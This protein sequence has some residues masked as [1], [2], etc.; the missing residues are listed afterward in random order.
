MFLSWRTGRFLLW[1]KCLCGE[2][3]NRRH[4]RCFPDQI[5]RL[6]DKLQWK[7]EGIKVEQEDKMTVVDFLLNEKEWYTAIIILSEFR[8]LLK[9]EDDDEVDPGDLLEVIV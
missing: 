1:H 4:I 5:Y 8:S 3:W 7:W 2:R 6:S 9:I